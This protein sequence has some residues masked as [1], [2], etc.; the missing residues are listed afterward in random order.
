[1]TTDGEALPPALE[2]V[3][4]D[5]PS[6]RSHADPRHEGDAWV[7]RLGTQQAFNLAA[8]EPHIHLVLDITFER[9]PGNY[10]L[11]TVTNLR[12]DSHLQVRTRFTEGTSASF[13]TVILTDVQGHLV[14]TGNDLLTIVKL[15]TKPAYL[16]VG[17]GRFAL[18][19]DGEPADVTLT[20]DADVE[21]RTS[22]RSLALPDQCTLRPGGA[23][24]IESLEIGSR[25]TVG[26]EGRLTVTT[27][28][29]VAG[30]EPT[31][32][33]SAE[34]AHAGVSVTARTIA[35]LKIG[36]D[37]SNLDLTIIERADNV[38]VEG[39]AGVTIEGNAFVREI[40]SAGTVTLAAGPTAVLTELGGRWTIRN[41]AGASLSGGKEG[42]EIHE[43]TP[44]SQYGSNPFGGASLSRF[45]L[46]N[47]SNR[48]RILAELDAAY[49]LDPLP[50]RLPGGGAA[51]HEHRPWRWQLA[52]DRNRA[53]SQDAEFV[54]E[55]A[56]QAREHG[57]PGS[58]RTR[59]A[60]CAYRLRHFASGS[61]WERRALDGY[62]LL[63]YGERPGPAFLSWV[64]VAAVCAGAT[65]GFTPDPTPDG[66]L[67]F[68]GAGI[69]QAL[70]P[71][72][73]LF[74]TGTPD[75]EWWTYALRTLVAIPLITGALALRNYVKQDHR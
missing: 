30:G 75:A 46:S 20:D 68:L 26:L 65:L 4:D 27:L 9:V 17:P 60:W 48:R 43:I 38:T 29:G 8:L 19:A 7:V 70:G 69:E 24:E 39:S 45:H 58:T 47:P 55:L 18:E 35:D 40:L 16:R 25:T 63:G 61:W 73:S 51:Y 23:T 10:N 59:V 6:A 36:S 1:M 66:L 49:F 11:A 57:A 42:F 41:A 67:R 32:T 50:D 52:E 56:R 14:L 21:L 13:C 72:G 62:R 28:T 5:N 74:G 33:L 64:A 34:V 54:R 2:R 37:A 3:L 12:A 31:L 53:L 44:P 15:T 22:L 71:V